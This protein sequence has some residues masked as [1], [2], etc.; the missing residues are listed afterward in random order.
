MSP[1]NVAA[2]LASLEII[3]AEPERRRRLWQITHK[4]H[5]A[6][7]GMG[8]DTGVSVTPIIPILIGEQIR[9]FDLWKMLLEAGVF[10][11]AVIPPAV[12]PGRCMLRTSYQAA[13]TEEQLD[14]VL[15]VFETLGKRLKLI[16][17]SRPSTSQRIDIQLKVPDAIAETEIPP[18]LTPRP[19]AAY[20]V[21]SALSWRQQLQQM[22]IPPQLRD[23]VEAAWALSGLPRPNLDLDRLQRQ[24]QA[25]VERVRDTLE[26]VTYR[27]ASLD[28]DQM[29]AMSRK[30]LDRVRRNAY[31]NGR[32]G[33]AK[34]GYAKSGHA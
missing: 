4:M 25:A 32:N 15:D 21:G 5:T 19:I 17:H 14:K 29:A 12:E 30:L 16:Q 24:G 6:F 23:R 1:A 28:T 27:A 31:R 10:T 2:T 8:F 18:V 26:A 11:N 3:E 7:K 9:T 13:H 34:N 20:G 33:S 22:R